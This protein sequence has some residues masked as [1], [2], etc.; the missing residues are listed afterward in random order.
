MKRHHVMILAALGIF[1][2]GVFASAAVLDDLLSKYQKTSGTALSATAGE[3]LW[4]E[5]HP[6]AGGASSHSCASCHGDNLRQTGK[7]E[8]T[9]KKIDAMPPR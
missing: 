3:V 4:K 6:Q 8:K 5:K 7:H 2:S 9:G 1:L